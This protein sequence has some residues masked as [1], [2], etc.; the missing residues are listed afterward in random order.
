M[1]IISKYPIQSGELEFNFINFND[2][3][4]YLGVTKNKLPNG[5]GLFIYS[6]GKFD[7]GQYKVIF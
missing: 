7:T 1:N 6:D 3:G 4:S 2:G 5:L